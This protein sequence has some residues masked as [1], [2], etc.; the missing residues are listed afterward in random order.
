MITAV[1]VLIRAE[2]ATRPWEPGVKLRVCARGTAF[3][4]LA[5]M[6]LPEPTIPSFCLGTTT[7]ERR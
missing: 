5:I 4:P 1:A 7:E 3:K 6:A 2:L